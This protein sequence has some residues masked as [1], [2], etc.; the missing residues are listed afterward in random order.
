MNENG[1]CEI[2]KANHSD[3]YCF[4]KKILP[5]KSLIDDQ[6]PLVKVDLEN[7]YNKT[8]SFLVNL[9]EI[10]KCINRNQKG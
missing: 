3:G 2:C 4:V 8:E 1:F 7:I 10:A 9:K 6:I 5:E